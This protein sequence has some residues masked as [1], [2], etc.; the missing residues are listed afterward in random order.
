[1]LSAETVNGVF[2]CAESCSTPKGEGH[3]PTIPEDL[4]KQTARLLLDEIY[5][6]SHLITNG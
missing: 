6:V 1:M 2:L 4:G 5:R 3:T